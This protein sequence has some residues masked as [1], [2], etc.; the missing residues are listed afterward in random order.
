M[1][2]P[3]QILLTVLSL[4]AKRSIFLTPLQ[5]IR[6]V[7]IIYV[8]YSVSKKKKLFKGN[9]K[10]WNYKTIARELWHTLKPWGSGPIKGAIGKKYRISRA[11]MNF[12][13]LL[14]DRHI[15]T[16]LSK[17]KTSKLKPLIEKIKK[18]LDL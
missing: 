13:E 8:I 7:Y 2:A 3:I 17:L 5:I 6:I 10:E 11:D 15:V 14:F 12:I 9:P 16:N 18:E 4:A 1:Y